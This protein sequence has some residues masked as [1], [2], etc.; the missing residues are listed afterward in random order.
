VPAREGKDAEGRPGPRN[1]SYSWRTFKQDLDVLG[2]RAQRHYETRATFINLAEGA[3]ASP[4]VVRRITHP[5]IRD[6]KDLYSRARLRWPAMCQT[7]KM[8]RLQPPPKGQPQD[9]PQGI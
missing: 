2:L 5:S 4:E 6:A 3:G 9:Q 7:V 8:I 1:N